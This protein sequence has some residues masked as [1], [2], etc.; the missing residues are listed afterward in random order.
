MAERLT[1]DVALQLLCNTLPD[2][3]GAAG[4]VEV[5]IPSLLS[6][7]VGMPQN[8]AWQGRTVYTS[9]WKHPVHGPRMVRR[10]N[11]DGDG[12]GDLARHGG[13][14]RA[15]FVYQI[16]SYRYWQRQLSR[17]GFT[18]FR[19]LILI[20]V[21]S[22]CGRPFRQV[23][24]GVQE[25]GLS[26]GLCGQSNVHFHPAPRNTVPVLPIRARWASHPDR[27]HGCPSALAALGRA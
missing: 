22:D 10:L 21:W 26:A 1:H 12:Q 2:R 9:V 13:E 4:S 14:H 20:S 5:K 16:D 8:V 17:N 23:P 19:K 25:P 6:V 7:N 15:V 11:V 18:L 27:P 24:Q 3:H